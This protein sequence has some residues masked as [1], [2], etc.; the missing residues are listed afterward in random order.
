MRDPCFETRGFAALLSMRPKRMTMDQ[1][2]ASQRVDVLNV[3]R[4]RCLT[5][6]LAAILRAKHLAITGGDIDLLSVR[7]VQANRHQ[8]A[9]RLH[10]VEALPALADV[11]AAIERAVLRRGGNAETRIERVGVLR[12]NPHVAPVGKG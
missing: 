4:Q 10:L 3:L 2:A 12:G 8:R 11:L 1:L 9:V 6:G 5:P 7:G